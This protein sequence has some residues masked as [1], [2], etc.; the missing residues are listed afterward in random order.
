MDLDGRG[1]KGECVSGSK[2]SRRD[3]RG[4]GQEV[5]APKYRAHHTLLWRERGGC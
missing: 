3:V 5:G 2:R 4:P 1:V